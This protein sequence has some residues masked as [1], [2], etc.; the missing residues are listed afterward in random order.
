MK[1]LRLFAASIY[2]VATFGACEGIGEY[3]RIRIVL[4]TLDTLRNDRFEPGKSGV[5]A[6]SR[7]WAH[8]ARGVVFQRYYTVSPVTQPTHATL[9]TGRQPW[10]HG[11]TRN[12]VV[13]SKE[14]PTVVDALKR[15]GFETSAIVASFPLSRRFGFARGFDAWSEEFDHDL[16]E[17]KTRWEHDWVVE[18]GAFFAFGD[19]ISDRAINALN[20]STGRKQFFWFHYFDPH[21]PYGAS[22]GEQTLTKR[23]IMQ[24]LR[25]GSGHPRVILERAKKLYDSDVDYLDASLDRLFRALANEE[26]K[27]ETHI[28]VVSDHGESLGEGDSVG[29]GLRLNE[30]ELRV[31]AFIISPRVQPA[32][33]TDVASAIDVAPTLL[34]L[35][36]IEM[37]GTIL[38]GRDLTRPAPPDSRAFAMR[39]TFRKSGNSELRLDGRR[40]A[41]EDTVFCEIDERGR[42]HRGN[43]EGLIDG[44]INLEASERQQIVRR[45]R[46]FHKSFEGASRSSVLDVETLRGLEALGYVE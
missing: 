23:D 2:F 43:H 28:V 25:E 10:E 31:P 32:I 34:S 42:I 9:F 33:S 24:G 44:E 22:S 13:L 26:S 18:A 20:R 36:G 11:I 21:P 35:A 15:N 16:R 41:L 37:E 38:A 12:G 14:I 45:F 1:K 39:R 30:A 46:E 8:A 6:M 3:P 5:S 29:H 17:N 4:I 19:S 7:T 40:Y 27:F